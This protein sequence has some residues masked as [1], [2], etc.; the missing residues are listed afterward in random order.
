MALLTKR[1]ESNRCKGMS[2]RGNNL[3]CDDITKKGTWYEDEAYEN[4]PHKL[5]RPKLPTPVNQPKT[6]KKGHFGW[7]EIS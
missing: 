5:R 3:R 6:P 4:E 1:A 2:K 7:W